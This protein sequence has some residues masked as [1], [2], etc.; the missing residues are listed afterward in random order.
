MI[1]TVGRG[2]YTYE[3]NS[4]W[5]QIPDFVDF[6]QQDGALNGRTHAVT[7]AK[8]GR[9]F[10]FNQ[11]NYAIL[12]FNPDGSYAGT[13]DEF[14]SSHFE[15]AHGLT[16][17]E[18]GG[19]EFLWLTDEYSSE[20][21]KTTLDG[22]IVLSI[23]R[24]TGG[25]Y[26]DADAPFLPTWAAQAE[27]GTIFVSDGYGSRHIS[28][29]DK[30]GNYIDSFGGDT[31][32][33]CA[34]KFFG[35]HCIW[36]GRRPQATGTNHQVIYVTDRA[37]HRVE[38]FDLNWNF[39]KSFLQLFP[40]CFDMGPAGEL[41]V[42]DAF[43]Y[44]QIY[45]EKDQPIETLGENIAVVNTKGW[46]DFDPKAVGDGKFNSPHGGCF[47]AEGNIYIVEWIVGGRITKLTKLN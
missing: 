27:D 26:A 8:D 30:D 38:V 4:N 35:V 22:E 43:A 47:D 7:V 19:R 31:D 34:G 32:K 10:I 46:P 15:G 1:T 39:V 13:W 37:N 36:I 28:R 21:V 33:P 20:V 17:H 25:V 14:P 12:I 24:P 41:L 9:V 3:W 23:D 16:R 18:E 2:E 6:K 11:S 29:Y 5:A 44:I 45:D 42:P 40:C